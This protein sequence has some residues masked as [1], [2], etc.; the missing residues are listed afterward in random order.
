MKPSK[1]F[2][3]DQS[4]QGSDS[5]KLSRLGKFTASRAGDLMKQQKNGKPYATR[6]NYITEIALERITGT[7]PEN[8]ESEAMREGK[9]R[10]RTA[11]LAY[12]FAT[13]NETE[14]TGFWHNE[15]YG[16]SPDDLIV[17]QDGGVE[18]KNP[19]AATHY[20]TLMDK[21]IPEHYYWQIIQCMLVTRASFWDYVSF[22][23]DF[24]ENAQLYIQRVE[25]KDVQKD[26]EN[27]IVELNKANQEAIELVFE[28]NNYK[29][30]K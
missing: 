14:Q 26:I 11:A 30:E 7:I 5:W 8:V 3:I 10:E 17:G 21:K 1:G 18:Y 9:E 19:Q 6:K 29:G 27:L 16:A 15:Y 28:I 4:E 13:G 20:Q 12:S 24:P 23:P 2:E 22:Q 25:A